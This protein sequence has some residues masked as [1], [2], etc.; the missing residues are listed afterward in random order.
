MDGGQF[1]FIVEASEYLDWLQEQMRDHRLGVID[2][3]TS[4]L[5]VA[6]AIQQV[7]NVAPIYGHFDSTIKV[8]LVRSCIIFQ[9]WEQQSLGRSV[10]LASTENDS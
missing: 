5:F 10:T 1:G 6:R 8:G 9:C 3:E 2:E 4:V 7:N